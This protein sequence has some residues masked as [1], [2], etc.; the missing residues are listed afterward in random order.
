MSNDVEER[1]NQFKEDLNKY[2][3]I[4]IVRKHIISGDCFILS[5]DKYFNLRS[6]VAEH[7]GLHPNEVFVVGSAKLGFSVAPKKRFR[8]FRRNKSDID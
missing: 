4:Q 1:L 5:Q 2:T 8:P 3:S 6:E 7:F